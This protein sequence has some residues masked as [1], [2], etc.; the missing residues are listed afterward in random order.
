MDFKKL[1]K[2]YFVGIGGIGISAVAKLMSKQGIEVAGAD[3]VKTEITDELEKYKIKFFNK[4]TSDNL[5][6]DSDLLIYSAAVPENNPERKKAKKVKIKQLSY[7]EVLG[8]ISKTKKTV[9]ISG[10]NGKTSTTA[11]AGLLLEEAGL[12]PLVI[13]GSKIDNFE[14]GN[15]RYGK[16]KYFAVEACEYRAHML[17]LNPKVIVLT[18]I[19]E[20]HLD[21]YSGIDEIK[22]AF[23]RFVDKL[24]EDGVLIYNADDKN[25]EVLKTDKKIIKYGIENLAS[26][27]AKNIYIEKGRQYFDLYYNGKKASQFVLNIPGIYNI[28]N[29]LAVIALGIHLKISYRKIK[30]SLENYH[31]A[32]RRFEKIG[33]KDGTIFISDYAHHPTSIAGVIRATR[34][35]YPHRRIVAV[36]QPH[37]HNRTKNLFKEFVKSLDKA[38]AVIINE[39]YDVAGREENDDQDVNSQKLVEAIKRRD[40]LENRN[41]E[42]IYTP[43]IDYTAREVLRVIDETDVVLILGA[44]DMPV[45]IIKNLKLENKNL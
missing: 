7:P 34:E 36:F 20:D 28:Y 1:K 29:A 12:D 45:D 33:E 22:S 14:D 3:L 38:D 35:F 15:L 6:D 40:K 37:Q 27:T 8:E 32:W 23:Q 16:G 17:N 42:V 4:H 44:G 43:D 26:V 30:K 24:P 2:V 11:L 9:A 5:E 41:R 39:I 21:F 13:V 18:N 31:G 25:S 10:T 19:E